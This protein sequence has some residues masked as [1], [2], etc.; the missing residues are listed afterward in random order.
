M[1]ILNI[2]PRIHQPKKGSGNY[3]GGGKYGGDN[4]NTETP[5]QDAFSDINVKTR[6]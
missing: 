2:N 4:A 5:P 1:N 6:Y 3:P